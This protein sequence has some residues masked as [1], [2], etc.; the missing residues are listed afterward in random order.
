MNE[1]LLWFNPDIE[2]TFH[3]N[4]V[5]YDMRAMSVSICKRYHLLDDEQLQMLE[6]LPKKD[7]TIKMGMLQKNKEFSDKLIAC[8]LQTRKEFLEANHLDESNVLSLHSDA[9]IFNSNNKITN[10]IDGVEFKHE[11]TWTSYL[12]FNGLEIFRDSE[13]ILSFKGAPVELLNRHALGIQLYL[14][15]IFELVENYDDSVL[16]FMRTFQQKYLMDKLQQ[17][18]YMSFGKIGDFKMYNLQLFAFIA[19]VVTADMKG[20]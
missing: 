9:C 4:I 16:D 19:R 3:S 12:R 17:H 15:K 8:E 2:Y 11:S 10:I 13:G 14:R 1:K 6:L 7:R 20:W 5:E 18:Y